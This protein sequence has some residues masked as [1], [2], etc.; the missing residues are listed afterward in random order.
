MFIVVFDGNGRNGI[1]DTS[2]DPEFPVPGD[3]LILVRV[4]SLHE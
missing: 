3:Q 1:N 4:S 2:Y